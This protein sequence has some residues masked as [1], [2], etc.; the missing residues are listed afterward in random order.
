LEH[1]IETKN[2]EE[3]HNY[4]KGEKKIKAHKKLVGA[5]Q[6]P[7]SEY[8]RYVWKSSCE[9]GSKKICSLTSVS[10]NC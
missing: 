7:T 2:R 8:Q 4:K 5:A 1:K 6:R 3:P 9:K 10:K